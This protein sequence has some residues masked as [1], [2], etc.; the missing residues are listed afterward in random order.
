MVTL[1]HP[2]NPN[3]TIRTQITTKAFNTYIAAQLGKKNGGFSAAFYKKKS[4]K[5]KSRTIE[6]KRACGFC[7]HCRIVMD[8]IQSFVDP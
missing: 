1:A 5:E 3:P 6:K 7:G 4:K 2:P 8:K